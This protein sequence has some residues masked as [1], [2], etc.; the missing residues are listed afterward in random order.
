MSRP[1]PCGSQTAQFEAI[2]KVEDT[3]SP[4][5]KLV[6]TYKVIPHSYL[7]D[8]QL[9][10]ENLTDTE[11]KVQFNLAGPVGIGPEGVGADTRKVVA[12][13]RNS[14]DQVVSIRLDTKKLNKA[15]TADERRL[16]SGGAGFLWA[17]IVNKYFAAI[18]VPVPDK[19]KEFCR[20]GGRQNRPILQ[21]RRR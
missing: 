18:V 13:F 16:A 14:Q 20:L 8:C 19:G 2:I 11:Q 15:K 3:G 17:A 5:I 4:A 7:L 1:D 12:A 6:K 9:T 10:I 21:S